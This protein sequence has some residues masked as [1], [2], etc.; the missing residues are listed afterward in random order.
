MK[1]AFG[2]A[3]LRESAS[4][5]TTATVADGGQLVFVRTAV[6]DNVGHVLGNIF[7]RMYHLANRTRESDAVVAAEL[8]SSTARLEEFLKLLLDYVSPSRL[9]LQL[10]SASEVVQ[11]LARQIADASGVEPSLRAAPDNGRKLL[12]DPGVLARSFALLAS[13]L[14]S[15][16]RDRTPALIAGPGDS[17]GVLVLVVHTAESKPQGRSSEAEMQWAVAERLIEIQGG[18]LQ[19]KSGSAGEV[20][21]EVTLPLQT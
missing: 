13:P 16:S 1:T 18:S 3:A 6:V 5:N 9:R 7:Q 20:T 4:A 15:A 11:S 17:D 2:S 14:R 19:E 12:V 21:W 10:V 8:E